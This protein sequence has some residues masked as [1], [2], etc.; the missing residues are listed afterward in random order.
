MKK[1][2]FKGTNAQIVGDTRLTKRQMKKMSAAYH[3][4][5]RDFAV[6]LEKEK[7]NPARTNEDVVPAILPEGLA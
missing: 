5:E 3:N 7:N 4:V 6:R 2:K 1:T